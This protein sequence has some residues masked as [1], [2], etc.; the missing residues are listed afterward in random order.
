MKIAVNLK[1]V[2]AA[3]M[4]PEGTRR[5]RIGRA[6]LYPKDRELAPDGSIPGELDKNGNQAY[7]RLRVGFVLEEHPS[8]Y[9]TSPSGKAMSFA[10]RWVWQGFGLAPDYLRRVY[11]L[12]Q[13][14]GTP[15]D[16]SGF[17]PKPLEGQ[18]VDIVV[19]HKAR[20]DDPETKEPVVQR[21]RI[22]LDK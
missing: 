19:V 6:E 15:Y 5:A 16:E 3:D 20:S 12:Y 2:A 9:G 8:N 7:G 13:N 10:G 14:S 11:E 1:D 18:V 17:E 4:V 22:A 21:V